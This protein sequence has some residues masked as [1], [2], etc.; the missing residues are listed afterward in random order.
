MTLNMRREPRRTS[1]HTYSLSW[2]DEDGVTHSAPVQG[3][4]ASVSGIAVRCPFEIRKGTTVYIQ[5][6]E[7]CPSGYTVVRHATRK[8]TSYTIGLE[9][10]EATKK[11]HPTLDAHQPSDPYEF[12]QISPKAHQET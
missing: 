3:I 7:G 12:L 2:Q 4:D 9:L 10:D 1:K 6:Y 11:A 8:G 5:A